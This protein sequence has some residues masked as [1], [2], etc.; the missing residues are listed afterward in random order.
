MTMIGGDII[1][2]PERGPILEPTL[3]ESCF[4]T[5]REDYDHLY[6]YIRWIVCMYV[7]VCVCPGSCPCPCPGE[8]NTPLAWHWQ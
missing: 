8:K 2:V 7:C 4:R 1:V 5:L 6:L 3:C